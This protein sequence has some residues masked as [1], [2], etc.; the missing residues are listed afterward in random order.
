MR[1]G[2][3]SQLLTA[4]MMAL[5]LLALPLAGCDGEPAPD[6][7]TPTQAPTATATPGPPTP[8]LTATPTPSPSYPVPADIAMVAIPE[9]SFSMG[10]EEGFGCERPVHT[11]SLSAFYLAEKETTYAQ[12]MGVKGWAEQ[13][14]YTFNRAGHMGARYG[15]DPDENHPA[16]EMEWYDAV[17]WCNA[18]SEIEGLTPVYYTSSAKNEVYRAGRIDITN[19]CVNWGADGYRLPTEAEWEYAC[20]A[21]TTT[22]YYFGNTISGEDANFLGSGDPFD[23]GTTPVGSYEPNAWGLYDM[24]GN[25][26]EWCWDWMKWHYYDESPV[27]NPHGPLEGGHPRAYRGGSCGSD[28]VFLRSAN[29]ESDFAYHVHHDRGFRIAQS[30]PVEG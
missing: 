19:D 22:E 7:Q 24:H 9:G 2:R 11:V 25:A 23:D 6:G 20:R 29:R 26:R 28:Y 15:G 17:L 3:R 14:G 16:T 5:A 10:S 30:C 12:W 18:L 27:S 21:G 13:N 4:V 1:V 8:A